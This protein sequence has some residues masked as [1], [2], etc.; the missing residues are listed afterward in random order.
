MNRFL[1]W[2]ERL[3]AEKDVSWAK[4]RHGAALKEA[5]V[6]GFTAA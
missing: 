1:S 3:S 4:Q 5:F 2:F 6:I